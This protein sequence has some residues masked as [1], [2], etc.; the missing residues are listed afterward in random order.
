MKKQFTQFYL[1]AAMMTIAMPMKAEV[2]KTNAVGDHI[3][4]GTIIDS[5]SGD[6][7]GPG[8]LYSVMEGD[9]YH[10]E[11]KASEPRAYGGGTYGNHKF[12][13]INYT[14]LDNGTLYMPLILNVFNGAMGWSLETQYG[15]YEFSSISSD[16]TFD[17]KSGRLYGCF[18]D[19][20]YQEC[21]SFGYVE[22]NQPA[23]HFYQSHMI[24]LFP[25]RMVAMATNAQGVMYSIGESGM[26]YT[27]NKITGEV[28]K[29]ASTGLSLSPF[30]QSAVCD[31]TTGDIFFSASWGDFWDTSIFKVDPATGKAT[32]VLDTSYDNYGNDEQVT[33]LFLLDDITGSATPMAPANFEVNFPEKS[34]SGT[35]SFAVPT[36]WTDNNAISGNLEYAVMDNGVVLK[37]GEAA[38]G[39][40]VSFSHTY[41][42][43]A[44]HDLQV[45]VMQ[46]NSASNYAACHIQIGEEEVTPEPIVITPEVATDFTAVPGENGAL[47][48]TLSFV[49]PSTDTKGQSL[50]APL[51]VKI[52]RNSIDVT[53]LTDIEPGSTVT[54]T[55][56]S[57]K[58]SGN[59]TYRISS[60]LDGEA[61]EEVKAV[62]YIG[63]DVPGAVQ[64][65]CAR[66]DFDHPG[67][68][69]LT[70]DAPTEGQHG[71]YIEP[72]KFTYYVSY[73]TQ[74]DEAYVGAN[75][76]F[77]DPL[78]TSKGQVYQAYSV[79]AVNDA[80]SGR[81]VWKTIVA[82]VGDPYELPYSDSF[83]GITMNNGSWLPQIVTGETGEAWWQVSDGSLL[84]SDTQDNDGGMFEFSAQE[85]GKASRISSP[86]V[87]IKNAAKPQLA[88][89]NYY[90]GNK[91]QLELDICV[92]DNDY[93]PVK[94]IVA[95]EQPIGWHRVTVDLTPYK[96]SRFV[97]VGFVGRAV[98]STYN[99]LGFDNII[100]ADAAN[101]DLQAE[102]FTG[103]ES[104]KVGEEGRF[105]F[106][107]R[108]LSE[109]EVDGLDYTVVLVK[110]GQDVMS[111]NGRSLGVGETA[112][113]VLTDE[114]T[115]VDNEIST[116]AARI[117]TQYDSNLANNTSDPVKVEIIGNN[118]P[119]P[120]A[121][122]AT[123]DGQ[124]QL[125]WGKPDFLHQAARAYTENFD[126]FTP[127]ITE[128]IGEWITY[129]ADNQPCVLMTLDSSFGALEYPG[130]GER[131]AYQVFSSLE[132]G[133]PFSSWDPHSGDLML[134]ALKCA[135]PDNGNTQIA[136][137]DWLISPELDGSEQTI[138]F[139]AKAGMTG[140]Y[141]PESYEFLYSTGSTNAEDFVKLGETVDLYNVKGWER[142]RHVVPEGAK[143]FAIRH[144]SLDKLAFLVDDITYIPEGA[145]VEQLDLLGY[146]VYRADANGN[147]VR[148]NVGTVGL[149]ATFA[150]PTAVEGETYTYCVTAVYEQGEGQPSEP[151]TVLCDAAGISIVT[152]SPLDSYYYNIK[153]QRV[154]Q[155][156]HPGVYIHGG[157]KVLK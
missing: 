67:T 58:Y 120:T 52:T 111:A 31:Q 150:D 127:F 102:A 61:S 92:D 133:I 115:S 3:F 88:F 27:V 140:S 77:S 20:D 68:V 129:D 76:T 24:G 64:N 131:M 145:E 137:D 89:W 51:E 38:P 5:Y 75:R 108:N 136:N 4:Y 71:G 124:T 66:E 59:Y 57:V 121:L 41:E 128:N 44:L 33:G 118:Y 42:A 98:E 82:L 83:P 100:F 15:S 110:N 73:G 125:T 32:N 107:I 49:A 84:G 154:A 43:A 78:D 7:T 152:A 35:I 105:N 126:Y 134:L 69:V 56:E 153:G 130:A 17:P 62:C 13:A 97:K 113:F 138:S 36:H 14:E 65:L 139:Y 11:L 26:L 12:Y 79:Y 132:A 25:E 55:D 151:L 22:L 19:A 143:R 146:N 114:A 85:V 122:A 10:F 30:Y 1:L 96:D 81:N 37:K 28:T 60:I 148:L 103:P 147:F 95:D 34:L 112:T 16:L 90:T 99:C 2:N 46:N 141:I 119:A 48:A 18:Y 149:N 91:D 9:P 104:I 39:E 21:K 142:Q 50:T 54:Y 6:W 156:S 109:E 101:A 117:E 87:S 86:R 29:I 70:W 23:E 80:G 53:T 94:T 63:L 47:Q 144:T 135:S 40:T 93:Q 116:Y 157:N 72:E 45:S 8:G 155:P 123:F 106:S 74:G